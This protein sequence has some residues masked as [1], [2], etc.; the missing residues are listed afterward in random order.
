MP[1]ASKL[2]TVVECKRHHRSQDKHTPH[3]G[4]DASVCPRLFSTCKT[5][6]RKTWTSLWLA[7]LWDADEGGGR[8]PVVS[9]RSTIV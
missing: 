7:S 1:E 6:R 2:Y 4:G 9:L 3:L 8:V 5:Q